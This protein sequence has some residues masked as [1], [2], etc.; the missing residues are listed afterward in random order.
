MQ[1]HERLF[2]SARIYLVASE[3]RANLRKR[4]FIVRV[5]QSQE[6]QSHHWNQL[7]LMETGV[8]WQRQAAVFSLRDN[9][10]VPLASAFSTL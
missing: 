7:R 8:N 1:I 10:C 6:T 5:Q 3:T 9:L 4:R 2:L